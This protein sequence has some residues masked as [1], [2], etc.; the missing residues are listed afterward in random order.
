VEE[1]NTYNRTEIRNEEVRMKNE[2]GRGK[3]DDE[4]EASC[5]IRIW[6]IIVAWISSDLT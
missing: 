3:T 6:N 4:R 5:G 1:Q 2:D